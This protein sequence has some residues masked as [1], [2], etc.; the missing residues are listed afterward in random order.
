MKKFYTYQY[1][2]NDGTPYYVGKGSGYRATVKVGRPCGMPISKHRI[3]IQYW[4]SESEAFEMEMWWIRFWG[5]KDIG[6]GILQNKSDGGEGSSNWSEERRR[7]QIAR[8]TGRIVSD[9]QKRK[10]SESNKGK[11][12]VSEETRRKMR[13]SAKKQPKKTHCIYG[14]EFTPENTYVWSGNAKRMCRTC[15]A[16]RQR[17]YR[18]DLGGRSA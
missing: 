15:H 9:E 6:T 11:H 17:K 18:D 1:L 7:A 16:E 14:H 13:E 5:R 4:D 3:I 10:A 12:V 8:L 2:R